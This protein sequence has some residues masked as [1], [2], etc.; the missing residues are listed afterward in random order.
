MHIFAINNRLFV[1]T[2]ELTPDTTIVV[3]KFILYVRYTI[4]VGC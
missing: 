4:L 3:I 1:C 2:K